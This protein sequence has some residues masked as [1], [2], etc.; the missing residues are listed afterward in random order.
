MSDEITVVSPEGEG[1]AQKSSTDN[2]PAEVGGVGS[3]GMK[4]VRTEDQIPVEVRAALAKARGQEVKP[5]MDGG[6]KAEK[7]G[8]E[9]SASGTPAQGVAGAPNDAVSQ[10]VTVDPEQVTAALAY[11]W[12][13]DQIQEVA[14]K[15][16]KVLEDL[17]IIRKQTLASEVVEEGGD[18]SSTTPALEGVT[19]NDEALKKLREQFGDEAVNAL[20]VP[21]ATKLNG[22][23]ELLNAAAKHGAENQRSQIV[24]RERAMFVSVNSVFDSAAKQFPELGS[25]AKLPKLS[26]GNFDSRDPAVQIRGQ[27]FEKAS[28][29]MRQ[30]ASPPDA[31][32]DAL[33]WYAGSQ[34]EKKVE[35]ALVQEALQ[36]ARGMSPKPSERKTVEKA[37]TPNEQK[38][39]IVADAKKKA[40]IK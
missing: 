3:F 21:M 39:S 31:M 13:N 17:A 27:V 6:V 35:G 24:G 32:K 40:G 29:F 2:T 38:V 14:K 16:P 30:G 12:T 18:D 7:T 23:V 37:L 26:N 34:T 8:E 10:S 22:V 25:T 11:G 33:Q 5:A 9:N 28:A 19:L 15:S 4:P 36:F 1:E 20:F